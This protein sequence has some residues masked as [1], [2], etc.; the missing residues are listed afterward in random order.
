MATREYSVLTLDT[1]TT[2]TVRAV[3]TKGQEI[4]AR[5]F[6][7]RPGRVTGELWHEPLAPE[8]LWLD[9][10]DELGAQGWELTA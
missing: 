6:A 10:L 5:T 4:D 8:A 7:D 3:T 1:G 2:P 9:P